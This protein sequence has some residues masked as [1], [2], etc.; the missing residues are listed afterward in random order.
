MYVVVVTEKGGSQQ[1]IELSTQQISIGR[2][3]GN[4]VV[5]PRGNVSKRHATIDRSGLSFTL[6]DLGSTNGTFVNGRRVQQAQHVNP[7]DKIY[8]GDFILHI[9]IPNASEPKIP[10]LNPSQN[11]PTPAANVVQEKAEKS[12]SIPNSIRSSVPPAIPGK[13]EPTEKRV[14]VPK[15]NPVHEAESTA[16]MSVSRP[17][18]GIKPPP[19]TPGAEIPSARSAVEPHL[20]PKR[21]IQA[22][23]SGVTTVK[24]L[25]ADA[26]IQLGISE[27]N[28]GPVALVPEKAA[29]LRRVLHDLAR[30]AASTGAL[31]DSHTAATLAAESFRAAVDL[32]PI[33]SWLGD[34][35][36]SEIRIQD[37]TLM[38]RRDGTFIKEDNPFTSV[39]KLIDSMAR[40]GAGRSRFGPCYFLEDGA[41]VTAI[42]APSPILIIDKKWGL[43]KIYGQNRLVE[44]SA[45]EAL[46]EAIASEAKIAIAGK[47]PLARRAIL[48]EIVGNIPS[49]A[50]TALVGELPATLDFP[51]I[52]FAARENVVVKNAAII[53]AIGE[54]AVLGSDWLVLAGTQ[55]QQLPQTL[56]VAS[57]RLGVVAELPLGGI[58]RMHGELAV[59]LTA[60]GISPT[61]A[62]SALYLN[63]AFDLLVITDV[64][65]SGVPC[66]S[67]V[68]ASGVTEKGAWSPRVMY[69]R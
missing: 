51:F 68:M 24:Q 59:S 23:E 54:A 5:L 48:Q 50:L 53:A 11:P 46:V 49:R 38:L 14:R 2:V 26:A 39:S 65:E 56:A 62:Q 69:Q 35:S 9:E 13:R 47:N 44:G 32:G 27:I 19:P 43:P 21:P 10:V 17:P 25:L 16:P 22:L 58:G 41:L 34:P 12:P 37:A 28:S 3:H 36:I 31:S 64:D 66:V 18:A 40:L 45:R 61:P 1:R 30:Y 7:G 15:L 8:V 52:T 20:A 63:A 33:G 4:D 55:F 57:N 29:K 42:E 6:N 60:A 67:S